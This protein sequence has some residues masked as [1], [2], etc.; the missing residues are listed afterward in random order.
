MM[1]LSMAALVMLSAT[2]AQAAYTE[3]YNFKGDGADASFW[4]ETE[5]GYSG[6]NLGVVDQRQTGPNAWGGQWGS[7]SF[8]TYDWCT[9]D[10]SYGWADLS[11]ATFNGNGARGA[12]LSFEG[13]GTT[14][15][16]LGC[17]WV[18]YETP[19]CWSNCWLDENGNEVCEEI[20]DTGYWNCQWDYVSV[21]VSLDLTWSPTDVSRGVNVNQTK[22]DG[23]V[24]RWRSVGSTG[25]GPVSG[26]ASFDGHTF[27]S[28]YG[29]GSCWVSTSGQSYTYHF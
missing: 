9:G 11:G 21:P 25:W 26:S 19:S 14:E 3:Q 22:G 28:A 1:K 18:D 27:D 13:T 20:C 8:Y 4:T 17:E 16:F 29:Y 6:L 10:Y 12:T 7:A 24:Q 23:Y 5:C 2:V 15:E